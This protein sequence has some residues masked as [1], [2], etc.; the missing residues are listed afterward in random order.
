MRSLW[1]AIGVHTAFDWAA[2]NLG[3]GSVVLADTHLL[4]VQRTLPVPAE[5]LVSAVI[6]ALAV[7][8]LVG[9]I[10]QNKRPFSWSARLND[11]GK[12]GG[13]DD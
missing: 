7:V 5:D 11:Q 6:V 12:L 10:Q 3:L 1:L 13:L 9:W 2:I 8:I 4:D